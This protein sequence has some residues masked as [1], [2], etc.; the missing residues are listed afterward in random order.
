[1]P[2]E[3]NHALRQVRERVSAKISVGERLFTRWEFVD[4]FEQELADFIMPDVTW[5]GGISEL[6][7]MIRQIAGKYAHHTMGSLKIGGPG[8]RA[9]PVR[10]F[11]CGR[12]PARGRMV[13]FCSPS[14]PCSW[15]TRISLTASLT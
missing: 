8:G 12:V 14:P 6:K 3:S 1:M 5:T 9:G 4:I 2:V 13:I 15:R 10:C 11:W 7:K